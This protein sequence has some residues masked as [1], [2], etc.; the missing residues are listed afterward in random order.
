MALPPSLTGGVKLTLADRFP[1]VAVTAVGAPGTVA[2][3]T[4][5]EAVDGALEPA[6]FVATTVKVY[7]VPFVSPVTVWLNNVVPALLSTPPAGF[8]TTV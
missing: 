5:F 1:A 3:V 4:L 6:A 8:D 2:G 7:A